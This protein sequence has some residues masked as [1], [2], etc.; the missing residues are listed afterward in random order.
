[1]DGMVSHSDYYRQF[2][3]PAVTQCVKDSIGI[4]TIQ[5]STDEH[6]NDIALS[7]WDSI[8]SETRFCTEPLIKLA[9]DFYSLS[10]GVCIA[11]QAARMLIETGKS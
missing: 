10:S 3:T 8:A 2:V 7:R 11:K 4:E 6:L 1:M 9:G 5:K